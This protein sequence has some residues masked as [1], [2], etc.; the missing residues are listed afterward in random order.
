MSSILMSMVSLHFH[1]SWC[2]CTHIQLISYGI[3]NPFPLMILSNLLIKLV[4]SD[5]IHNVKYFTP[6]NVRLTP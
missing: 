1:L 2:R 3:F 6:A 4:N 5:G